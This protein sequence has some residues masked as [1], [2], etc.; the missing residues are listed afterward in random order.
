MAA[1]KEI[2]TK[3]DHLLSQKYTI[4]DNKNYIYIDY[5][6]QFVSEHCKYDTDRTMIDELFSKYFI[7]EDNLYKFL[8]NILN[9]IESLTLI[10][11]PFKDNKITIVQ[12]IS[13]TSYFGISIVH[14]GINEIF[15][16]NRSNDANEWTPSA[17]RFIKEHILDKTKNI[18]IHNFFEFTKE[19]QDP[20]DCGNQLAQHHVYYTPLPYNLIR[21]RKPNLIIENGCTYDLSYF[22]GYMIHGIH[23]NIP[24]FL[25]ILINGGIMSQAMIKERSILLQRTKYEGFVSLGISSD[26]INYVSTSYI[27]NPTHATQYY[28]NG[29][30][31]IIKDPDIEGYVMKAN[32]K[33]EYFVKDM[34]KLS[35]VI[36]AIDNTICNIL[37]TS[38]DC[39]FL[40]DEFK[41]KE[42]LSQLNALLGKKIDDSNLKTKESYCKI[43][44]EILENII[45]EKE[46]TILNLI[47]NILRIININVDYIIFTKDAVASHAS[48]SIKFKVGDEVEIIDSFVRGTIASIGFNDM[49]VVRSQLGFNYTNH[50]TNLKKRTISAAA[51]RSGGYNP[52]TWFH[53]CY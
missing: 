17:V 16:I 14:N 30:G 38:I 53:H 22:N 3:F 33:G 41:R 51:A 42:I 26:M 19:L 21:R 52:Y 35:S 47:K 28:F 29:I 44:Y 39:N 46:K 10:V 18:S 49:Y 9:D 25:N 48:H 6:R 31:F 11:N 7:I 27:G 4:K 45:I 43:F 40:E 20:N 50:A 36:I 23:M 24:I 15:E 13:E 34:I 12:K 1:G 2:E 5:Y 32:M 37:V 8:L